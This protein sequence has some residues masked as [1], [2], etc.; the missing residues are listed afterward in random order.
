MGTNARFRISYIYVVNTH[1][2]MNLYMEFRSNYYSHP[3]KVD[4]DLNNWSK[5]GKG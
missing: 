2:D 4:A 3:T 1:M 5:T